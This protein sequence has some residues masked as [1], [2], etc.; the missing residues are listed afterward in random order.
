MV[1]KHVL[2]L[3]VLV[4]GCTSRK[5]ATASANRWANVMGVKVVA[6][7]CSKGYTEADCTLNT[8]SNLIAL[9]CDDEDCHFAR[10]DVPT[11]NTV[12]MPITTGK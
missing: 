2:L 3:V 10:P 1:K 8:G 9:Q 5:E 6:V 7:T 12:V 4:I 11:N